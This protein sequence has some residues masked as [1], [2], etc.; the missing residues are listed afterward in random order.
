MPSPQSRAV[1]STSQKGGAGV[2]TW[3]LSS[4]TQPPAPLDP[5]ALDPSML[6]GAGVT[7]QPRRGQQ[8]PDSKGFWSEWFARGRFRGRSQWR[9]VA[10]SVGRCPAA[11]LA[12]VSPA[13]SPS[14]G[15]FS[16]VRGTKGPQCLALAWPQQLSE[17]IC[18]TS[19]ST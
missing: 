14:P 19:N 17:E 18:S 8:R 12:C 2:S 4:G 10:G 16:Q 11:A 3:P 5:S 6:G 15:G 7:G 13:S 1:G 9:S